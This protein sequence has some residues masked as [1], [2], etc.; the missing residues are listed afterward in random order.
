MTTIID[1]KKIRNEILEKVKKEV[2]TLSFQP[3]FCDILVGDDP[4][5]LQYVRMKTKTAESIG[6]KFH[7][8]HLSENI[9]EEEFISEI[10]KIN[11]IPNICGLIVQLPLPDKF[12]KQRVLNVISSTI[13]VDCLN[14][15]T[16]DLFY[17]NKSVLD[18]PAA[19]AC[20]HILDSLNLNLQDPAIIL[21]AGKIVVVGQGMLVGKPVAHILKNRGLSVDVVDSGTKDEI[22]KMFLKNADIIISATGDGKSIKGDMLK[23]GVIIIDAGTSESNGG[24]SGDVDLDS[25]QGVASFVSPVP[26]GVGPVTVAMLLNNVLQVAKEKSR[27]LASGNS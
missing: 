18:F 7:N 3:V 21:R 12:D 11:E 20:I 16:S 19:L 10:K 14:T 5:S 27:S 1:G 6:I 17:Q 13:D 9:N 22:K 8:V 4:V 2:A 26:G 24:I 15:E 25:V 23:Q